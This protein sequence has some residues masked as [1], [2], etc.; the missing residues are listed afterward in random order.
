MERIFL[1]LKKIEEEADAIEAEGKRLATEILRKTEEEAKRLEKSA[2]EE[3]QR[4][5]ERLFSERLEKARSTSSEIKHKAE[6]EGEEIR[7]KAE[8]NLDKGVEEV[9]KSTVKR[10][11]GF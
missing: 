3:A 10:F 8:G 5:G 2:E 11:K 6:R 7:K 9:V 1:G 4:E